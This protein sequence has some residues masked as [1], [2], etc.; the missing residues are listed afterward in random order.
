M[1]FKNIINLPWHRL[2]GVFVTYGICRVS[3]FARNRFLGHFFENLFRLLQ[4]KEPNASINK[5]KTGPGC[6]VFTSQ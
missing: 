2:S 5:M 3:R 1:A 4:D 6:L